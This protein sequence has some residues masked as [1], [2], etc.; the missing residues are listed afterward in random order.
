MS[1]FACR[2]L[3][4]IYVIINRKYLG[5]IACSLYWLDAWSFDNVFV[6]LFV[7]LGK[8]L[9]LPKEVGKESR[10]K[11]GKINTTIVNN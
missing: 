4:R 6:C 3:I 1:M 5:K 10:V 7:S 2:P 11:G 8:D 9:T